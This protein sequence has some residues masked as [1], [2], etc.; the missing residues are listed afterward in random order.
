[1]HP[2]PDPHGRPP[3]LEKADPGITPP[4]WYTVADG[5]ELWWDGDRWIVVPPRNTGAMAPYQPHYPTH[6]VTTSP[7]Q[8]NHLL[9]LVLTLVT[10]GFWAP[11]WALVWILNYFSEN[12]SVSRMQ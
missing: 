10:C 7:V 8:T 5:R 4:G 2:A 12:R 9:H 6:I 11:V 1:M 3:F